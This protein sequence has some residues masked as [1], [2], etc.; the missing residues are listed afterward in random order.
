MKINERLI[1][2][3]MTAY[4]CYYMVDDGPHGTHNRNDSGK[5]TEPWNLETN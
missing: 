3:L 4:T 1:L 5:L 2:Y